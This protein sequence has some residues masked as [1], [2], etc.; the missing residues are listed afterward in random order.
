MK[1]YIYDKSSSIRFPSRDMSVDDLKSSSVYSILFR[2]DC[3][4]TEVDGGIVTNIQPL[5]QMKEAYGVTAEDPDQALEEC[6]QKQ[7]EREEAAKQQAVTLTDI[8]AQMDALCGI[9]S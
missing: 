6:I 9:E 7:K 5:Y 2:T 1:Q 8:Q 4:L 3:V